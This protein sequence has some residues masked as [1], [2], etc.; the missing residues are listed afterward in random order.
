MASQQGSDALFR[1]SYSQHAHSCQ[2]DKQTDQVSK[3]IIVMIHLKGWNRD[4]CLARSVRKA[5]Q[6]FANGAD[7]I[8]AENHDSSIP[9]CE[10][11]LERAQTNHPD[12]IYGVNVPHQFE[13]SLALAAHFPPETLFIYP[14]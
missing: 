1:V 10:A 6:S 9:D 12:C 5:E 11:F 13:V 2:V 4:D 3:F 14:L 8:L 7:L